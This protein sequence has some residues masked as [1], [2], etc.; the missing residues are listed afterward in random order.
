MTSQT[1]NVS[2]RFLLVETDVTTVQYYW[3][4]ITPPSP[5]KSDFLVCRK[6]KMQTQAS[7]FESTNLTF[8]KAFF[9]KVKSKANLQPFQ[10]TYLSHFWHAMW[11]Q[12]LSTPFYKVPQSR[13]SMLSRRKLCIVI[14]TYSTTGTVFWPVFSRP[15]W[16]WFW[17]VTFCMQYCYKKRAHHFTKFPRVALICY[18]K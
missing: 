5:K 14:S 9:I 2:G 6:T 18:F 8:E 11:L 13:T 17:K 12:E 7:N 4:L 16:Y 3:L 15:N 10:Q 1:P